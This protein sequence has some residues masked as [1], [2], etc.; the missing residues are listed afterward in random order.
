MRGPRAA[1]SARER[2]ACAPA[3]GEDQR[4]IS[5]PRLVRCNKVRFGR[6]QI[7]SRRSFHGHESALTSTRDIVVIG[8]SAGGVEALPR[9]LQ[10][11]PQDLEAAVFIVQ[12]MAL[13]SERYLVG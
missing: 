4:R 10:Q 7:P 1:V 11:L 3:R 12:H 2:D 13:S 8:C 9:V 6:A 5:A